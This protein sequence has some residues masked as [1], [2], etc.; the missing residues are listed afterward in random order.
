MQ[1]F[2]AFE[3]ILQKNLEDFKQIS[4]NF[5]GRFFRNLTDF[6]SDFYIFPTTKDK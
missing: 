1:I 5:R 6:P 2:V 4:T 3:E